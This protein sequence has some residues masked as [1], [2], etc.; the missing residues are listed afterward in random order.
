MKK[1]LLVVGLCLLLTGLAMGGT[2][3]TTISVMDLNTSS[4]LSQKELSLLTDKLLNSLVEYRVYDV[5]ERSKRDEILKEQGFQMTGACSEASCL[6]E[7]G[8]LLGAQ[9]MIGGTIGKLGTI[10]VVELRMID[11]Q[12][13]GIDLSFSRNYGK[14]ADLLTAMKEAAEIFSSWK[15][16]AGQSS[17]PGGLFVVTEPDGAKIL[18]DGQEQTRLTPN[19]IY[20]L[21]EGLHQ[22]SL[23]KEGYSLFSTSRLVS[24]G[25]VDTINAPLMSLAGKLKIKTDPAGAKL[26]LN[27]KYQGIVTEQGITID[28][29]TDSLYKIKATKWGYKTYNAKLTPTPGRET[30]I[31]AR[32][33]LRRWKINFCSFDFVKN[34]VSSTEDVATFDSYSATTQTMSVTE[35]DFVGSGLGGGAGVGFALNR[36]VTLGLMYQF[37]IYPNAIRKN[38]SSDWYSTTM[39][40]E[41][42]EINFTSHTPL[43]N[44]AVA[45][46]W[47]RLEPYGEIRYGTISFS[48][49][50]DGEYEIQYMSRPSVDSAYTIDSTITRTIDDKV[51]YR[52]LQVGGGFLFW[53]K[54]DREALRVYWM[55]SKDS[56]EDFSL[57]ES[58]QEID[59]KVSG[60]QFGC[61]FTVHF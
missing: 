31:E 49:K 22:I 10:Y 28:D 52:T 27:K 50:A 35:D 55:Y 34:L 19:L 51:V 6:V 61:G 57:P 2:Q 46:P 11:I 16:G 5:V 36:N 45:V 21:S 24:I 56:F 41:D 58:Q 40:S 15:P 23:I 42:L 60:L 12:T 38:F 29:L 59:L 48:A 1:A 3:K 20:P 47:G 53:L 30:K 17:K 32:M 8:Q 13:G 26:F 4:G 33:P 54:P 37:R 9:K 25:K 39:Q 7:V 18:V 14:I 43:I 44:L